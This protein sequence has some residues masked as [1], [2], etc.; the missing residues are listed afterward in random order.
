MNC[1]CRIVVP[2]LV[3]A[4]V[5]SYQVKS[6]APNLPHRPR[7]YFGNALQFPSMLSEQCIPCVRI[8]VDFLCPS[9]NARVV[10]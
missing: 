8:V 2:V 5:V 7:S 9:I 4:T 6:I 3:V 10:R 1:N